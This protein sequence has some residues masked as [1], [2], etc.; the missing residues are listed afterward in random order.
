[1]FIS[2]YSVLPSLPLPYLTKLL[3]FDTLTDAYHFIQKCGGKFTEDPDQP[4]NKELWKLD[5][6]LSDIKFIRQA[7]AEEEE[8]ASAGLSVLEHLRLATAK[9]D[10]TTDNPSSV[11]DIRRK[12]FRGGE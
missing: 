6:K 4:T 7:T 2:I 12:R 11:L 10:S 8:F 5:C 3:G 9:D 1:M